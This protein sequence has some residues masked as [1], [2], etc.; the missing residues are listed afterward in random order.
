[1][2]YSRPMRVLPCWVEVNNKFYLFGGLTSI[3][4]GWKI[5]LLIGLAELSY[6]IGDY[7]QALRYVEEGVKEA[8]RTWS[9]IQ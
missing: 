7:A 8:Q 3:G 2:P 1:M 5:R 4:K 6:T 9:Q